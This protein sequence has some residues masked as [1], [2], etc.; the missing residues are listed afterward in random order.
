MSTIKAE[1][2]EKV[3]SALPERLTAAIKNSGLSYRDLE[4]MTGVPRSTIGN[5]ATGARTKVDF[6]SIKKLASALDVTPEYLYG[7]DELE[8]RKGLE[9]S[10]KWKAILAILET[11]PED[12]VDRFLE[13]FRQQ[14]ELMTGQERK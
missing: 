4:K 2:L 1:D 13:I 3:R 9:A 6:V 14:L 5:Y 7:L 8:T 11:M 10:P 12:Q